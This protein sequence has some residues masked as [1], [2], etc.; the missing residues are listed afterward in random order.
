M[1]QFI[2]YDDNGK[3]TRTGTCSDSDLL[4]QGDNV[5]EGVADDSIHM[6]VDGQVVDKPVDTEDILVE[7]R[8]IRN[9]ILTDTDWTQLPD[10]PVDKEAWAIYRQQL[11]DLP[12]LYPNLTNMNEVVFPEEP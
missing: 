1:K 4:I 3:I 6:I 7:L 2:V 8:N 10:A 11:R 9:I 5:I 12:G